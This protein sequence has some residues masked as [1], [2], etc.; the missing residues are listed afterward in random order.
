MTL[1]VKDNDGVTN[2]TECENIDSNGTKWFSFPSGDTDEYVR[3]P[4]RDIESV[5]FLP[6]CLSQFAVAGTCLFVMLI[7][8]V[9]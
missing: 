7:S 8:I 9:R 5:C 6:A 2:T 1:C 3:V 4:Y